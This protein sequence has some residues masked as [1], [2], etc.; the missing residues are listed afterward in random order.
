M[1]SLAKGGLSAAAYLAHLAA[2]RPGLKRMLFNAIRLDRTESERFR[3]SD[4]FRFLAYVFANRHRSRSQ[5]LQD[6]WVCYELEEKRGGVFVEFGA[7][8]GLVNSNSWLLEEKYGWTGI[9][10]EPNPVWH[11]DLKRNR[12]S[13]IDFR[14]VHVRSGETV[15][16]T[17][18]DNVD[19][20]LSCIS[21]FAAGDHFAKVRATGC[22]I[23]V[24][25][26]SLDRL[27]ADHK[28][29]REIDYLSID[30]EGSEYAILSAFDFSRHAVKLVSVEQNPT[31]EGPIEALLATHGYVRVFQAF[32]QWDGWYVRGERASPLGQEKHEAAGAPV[33]QRVEALACWI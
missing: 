3:E 12:S 6:L 19:P 17:A 16:F 22:Q 10:A 1:K 28:A 2:K 29:P 21:E 25:T 9:L 31:T 20:E 30:T 4:E 15:M 23:P 32:S 7:T 18:T 26:V 24:E 8:N 11:A 14:C 27:L 13:A 5:I 33:A